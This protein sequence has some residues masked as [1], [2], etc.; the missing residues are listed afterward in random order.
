MKNRM[1]DVLPYDHNR[2]QLP[3]TKV[4]L[5]R[6]PP[7]IPQRIPCGGSNGL[8]NKSLTSEIL[9]NCFDSFKNFQNQV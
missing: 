3:T 4:S 1:P 9:T 2:I 6:I 7:G 5:P 8:L